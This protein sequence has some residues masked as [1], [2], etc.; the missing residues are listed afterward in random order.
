MNPIAYCQSLRD[1][2]GHSAK[3]RP[4]AAAL[5]LRVIVVIASLGL[6]SQSQ[7]AARKTRNVFFITTDGLRWQEV[8]SGA[9][10]GLMN[11]SN[12][13]AHVEALREQ[14]WRDTPEAR[15][16]ALFPFLWSV[17]AS[18]GQIYG[19]SAR[20]SVARITNDKKFSYPGYSEFLTGAADSRIVS[21]KKIS[22]PNTNVFEWLNT[23][24]GFKGR[25]GAIVN[26]D[27]IPWIL[28]TARG[29]IPCWSGFPLQSNAL[30]I[31]ISP[32]VE[33]LLLDTTPLWDEMILDTFTIRAALDYVQAEEP[34]AFYVA[35]A[36]TDEWAHEVRYDYYLYSAFNV[37]RFVR[38]LW[39]TCQRIPQYRDQTTFIFTTDHGR[40]DGTNWT[41]HG[42]KTAGA[43]FIWAAI[44]G[45][46]TPP[47]GER[48][49][50]APIT[51]SQ[52]AATIA[53][54]LGEDFPAAHPRAAA[55]IAEAFGKFDRSISG[56]NSR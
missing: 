23:R 13:V 32:L 9:E 35:F 20:G 15:R 31:K 53:A 8:F 2:A 17:V 25:V 34:R 50:C 12:G 56:L 3:T 27:A 39:E 5:V 45:P 48:Q 1:S 30:A 42:E 14:F 37:D 4:C 33:R 18:N 10:Q 38:N 52:M 40:G 28:N 22:N 7:A 47:L 16:Q 19:N 11:K 55:P 49:N 21:N 51:Q 43:E 41:S 44:L 24:P 26:W 29:R 36:E 6:I 46:D 54:A